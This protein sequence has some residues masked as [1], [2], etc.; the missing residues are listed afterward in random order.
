MTAPRPPVVFLGPSLPLETARDILDAEYRPPAA[1]G[2]ILRACEMAPP[3]I[4]YVNTHEYE[5]QIEQLT[6]ST[7]RG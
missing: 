5:Q 4:G 1:Q 2:D 7:F 3:A 6:V